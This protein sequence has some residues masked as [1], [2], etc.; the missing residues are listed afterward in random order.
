MGQVP[1]IQKIMESSLVIRLPILFL[2]CWN[3]YNKIQLKEEKRERKREKK[4]Y[5]SGFL[6]LAVMAK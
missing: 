1:M 3:F 4:S 2:E 6:F 5:L